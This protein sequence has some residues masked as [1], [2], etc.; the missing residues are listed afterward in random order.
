[1]KKSILVVSPWKR[2]W[3]LGGTAGLADDYY[4]ITEFA[5]HG[6]EVHYVSPRYDGPPDVDNDQYAVHDF[7]DVLGATES[8]PSLIRR[9]LWPPLFTV[10]AVRRGL[11][12]SRRV[13][14]CF[15]LGQTHLSAWAVRILARRLRVPSAVKLFG[16]ENLD[17]QD[18]S[19]WK[20]LRSNLEQILAFKVKQDA[21]MILDDGTKGDDA[22]VRH[23]VAK[24]HVRTLPNGINLE[25]V[26]Q[27][28]DGAVLE[29]YGI[30][31]DTASVLFLARL[32][33]WKR[34]SLFIQAIP[35]I[36]ELSRRPVTFLI[37][38]DGVER[39]PTEALATRLGISDSVRFLGSVSHDHVPHIMTS[40]SLFAST[41]A[42]TNAGIPTCE[43]LV[44]GIPVV[45]FNVGN[46]SAVVRNGETGRLVPDADVERFAEAV[47][48]LLN[49]DDE[50]LRMGAQGRIFAQNTF[51][52]WRERIGMEVDIVNELAARKGE[53]PRAGGM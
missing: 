29:H 31:N 26:G 2:R 44:C 23:G 20:Y 1:M 50:R 33:A 4:F 53:Q 10:C 3:E 19:R 42:R 7:P 16:V 39:G 34:P 18:W 12:A 27:D 15:V 5:R 13:R 24:E 46:T 43:A 14:P 45:A 21:W 22:A 40:A 11:A 9:P 36:L 52:G 32:V 35:R 6:F 47:A 41:N 38:G 25:W 8:W 37:A 30:P 17:R 51:T 49:N 28:V 48:D